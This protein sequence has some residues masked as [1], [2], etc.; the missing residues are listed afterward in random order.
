[1]KRVFQ[2]SLFPL[3]VPPK[4]LSPHAME[5][6]PSYKKTLSKSMDDIIVP[7]VNDFDNDV[8][9]DEKPMLINVQCV[10]YVK[11]FSNKR[12]SLIAKPLSSIVYN[13]PIMEENWF[14]VAI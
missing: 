4:A 3:F 14:P 6:T 2:S 10:N 11:T 7:K 1:M 13:A 12:Q 5:F 8:D 9:L